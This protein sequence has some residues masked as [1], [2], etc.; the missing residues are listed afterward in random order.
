M[1]MIVHAVVMRSWRGGGVGLW[2]QNNWFL[3]SLTEQVHI[4]AIVPPAKVTWEA[5]YVPINFGATS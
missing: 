5:S 2:R 4:A 3:L 1:L